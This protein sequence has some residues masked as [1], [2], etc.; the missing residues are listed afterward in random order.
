M[1]Y[2]LIYAQSGYAYTVIPDPPHLR[3]AN[4]PGESHA[5]IGIIGTLSHPSPYIQ[6]SYGYLKSN[7]NSSNTN[8]PPASNMFLGPQPVYQT[9][10]PPYAQLSALA[11][12]ALV[13][14][15]PMHPHPQQPL[16]LQGQVFAQQSV[17]NTQNLKKKNIGKG[18]N[19]NQGNQV[20]QPSESQTNQP[21]TNNKK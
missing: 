14:Q 4:A 12:Q 1:W 8:D 6:K 17:T 19:C 7:T 10:A 13:P 21:N 9:I 5:T 15:P 3:G 2:D 20:N 16:C 11:C 18:A